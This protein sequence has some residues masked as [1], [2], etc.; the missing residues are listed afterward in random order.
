MFWE[1]ILLGLI[2]LVLGV[3]V[4]SMANKTKSNIISLEGLDLSAFIDQLAKA[5]GKEVAEQL[6]TKIQIQS[7]RKME[8]SPS[9]EDI[10][11][12]DSIIPMKVDTSKLESNVETLIKEEIKV[13]KDI[14]KNKAK[15]AS[16]MKKKKE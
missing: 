10:A 6:R 8:W 15:L 1:P 5:I 3:S 16:L 2:L 4:F 11:M 14:E 7:T 9:E 13:D 12:D